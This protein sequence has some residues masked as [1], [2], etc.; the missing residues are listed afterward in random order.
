[1]E[2]F[3][4]TAELWQWEAQTTSSWFFVSL[5]AD[6]ADDLRMEAGPPRGFGSIRVEVVIGSSV[7][8]TSVFPSDGTFVLP[9][10]KPVRVKEGIDPGDTV[11]VSVR[12]IDD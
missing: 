9:V 10:K 4:F 8:K 11:E 1:M 3:S 12:P 2:D 5:P 6:L 7:W